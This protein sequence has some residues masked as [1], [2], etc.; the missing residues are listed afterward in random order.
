MFSNINYKNIFHSS[1]IGMLISIIAQIIIG[2]TA[3]SGIIPAAI[4][5]GA[6]IGFVI[7]I[8]TETIT[9]ILPISIAKTGLFFFINNLI[10]I[11]TTIF[12]LF[13]LAYTGKMIMDIHTLKSVIPIA[14]IIIAVINLFDYIM[15]KRTN[16]KLKSYQ[17]KMK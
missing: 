10:A 14:V 8:I 15:Y 4:A 11:L 3:E 2:N 12:I 13:I 1:W 6:G 9:A 5:A 17:D 7:G 16:R